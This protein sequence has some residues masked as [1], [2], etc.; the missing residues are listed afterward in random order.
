[1]TIIEH[2]DFPRALGSLAALGFGVLAYLLLKRQ[3]NGLSVSLAQRRMWLLWAKNFTALVAGGIVFS[4]WAGKIAGLLFSVAAI[5][6]AL[7]VV[8]K[9]L[10]GN[11]LGGLYLTLTRPFGLNDFIEVNGLRG[12]VVSFGIFSITLV[13]TSHGNQ[14][15]GETATLPTFIF[16][17]NPVRNITATGAYVTYLSRISLSRDS[18]VLAHR[19]ALLHA[20]ETVCAPWVA[21]ANTALEATERR[22]YLELPSAQPKALLDLSDSRAYS[23]LLRFTCKPRV[24]VKTEQQ[25]LQLYLQAAK[26]LEPQRTRDSENQDSGDE[27]SPVK[28]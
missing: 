15:T 21:Q 2:Q 25:I 10:I 17:T 9:E 5:A 18:D 1:M 28:T 20:A 7:I 12:E 16:L 14:M 13:L 19:Q 6:A 23:I 11:I 4:L 8:S 24:R 3:V 22:D 27:Q 26:S